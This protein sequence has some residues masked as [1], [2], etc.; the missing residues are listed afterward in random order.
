MPFRRKP[1]RRLLLAAVSV[2]AATVVLGSGLVPATAATP[3]AATPTAAAPTAATPTAATRAQPA[4]VAVAPVGTAAA[5]LTATTG[6]RT[7]RPTA[8]R[9]TGDA[10]LFGV[11]DPTYDGVYRQGLA[12]LGLRAARRSVPTDALTWLQRQQCP[13]GGFAAY[14]APGS[15]CPATDTAAFTGEDTNSTATAA[16]ALLATGRRT[17][18]TRALA[19]LRALQNRDGGWGYLRGVASDANS[20]GLVL[21]AFRKAGVS[22]NAVR[23]NGRTGP[24]LLRSLQLRCAASATARGAL[25]YQ[26]TP[27]PLATAQGALGLAGTLPV[28]RPARLAVAPTMRCRNGVATLSTAGAGA[29]WLARTL[30]AG[31]GALPNAFGPGSDWNATAWAVLGLTASRSGRTAV[32]TATNALARNVSAFAVKDR[33]GRPAAYGMLLLVAGATGR[34]PRAFGGTDLVSALLRTKRA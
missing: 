1:A 20:T 28:A 16:M 26:R 31:K 5:A 3:T 6:G 7:G 34:N 2:G 27:N 25:T 4:S 12:I 30:L 9:A 17:A 10:G 11:Q 33:A 32:T 24:M 18:A 13:D 22:P 29:G 14:R 8:T 19:W 15:A 21:A 23:R